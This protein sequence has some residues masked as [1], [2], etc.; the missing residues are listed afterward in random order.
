MWTVDQANPGL[1]TA[2]G[3]G[4]L[5]CISNQAQLLA[6][7]GGNIEGDEHDFSPAIVSS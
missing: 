5:H 6:L 2:V 1:D 4:L 7:F 3:N